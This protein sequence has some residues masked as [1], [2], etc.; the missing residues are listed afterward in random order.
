[1]FLF[2]LCSLSKIVWIKPGWKLSLVVVKLNSR[3]SC[4]G[5]EITVVSLNPQMDYEKGLRRL[6]LTKLCWSKAL[7]PNCFNGASHLL[8]IQDPNVCMWRLEKRKC[9]QLTGKRTK[10]FLALCKCFLMCVCVWTQKRSVKPHCLQELLLTD[11]C[12][13]IFWL[14]QLTMLLLHHWINTRLCISAWII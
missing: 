12:L 5:S 13:W 6:I 2:Y 14:Q 8:M 9:T 10:Y 4:S 11:C 7:I 1:M 3:S